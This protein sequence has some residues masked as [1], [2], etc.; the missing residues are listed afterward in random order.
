M[1]VT[2]NLCTGRYQPYKK[3]KNTPTYINVNSNHQ[4]NI[5]KALPDSISKQVSNISSEEATFYNAATFYNDILSAT[6]YTKNLTDQ[7]D[8]P[9]SNKVRQRKIV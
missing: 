3:P 5:I 7:K 8:L 9:P 1:D 6:G 2:F 4:S